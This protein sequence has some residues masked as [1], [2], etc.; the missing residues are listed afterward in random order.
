MEERS[1]HTMPQRLMNREIEKTNQ[2]MRTVSGRS[3]QS[4]DNPAKTFRECIGYGSTF[5]PELL[6]QQEFKITFPPCDPVG[7]FKLLFNQLKF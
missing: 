6:E 2:S 7:T 3:K 5:P 1:R 4:T